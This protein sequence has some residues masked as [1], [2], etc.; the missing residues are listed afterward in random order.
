MKTE[1]ARKFTTNYTN[2]IHKTMNRI[3][4]VMP[5]SNGQ[6][7]TMNPIKALSS[8]IEQ[9]QRRGCN[10]APK[11]PVSSMQDKGTSIIAVVTSSSKDHSIFDAAN[12]HKH[13][14]LHREN[15][16]TKK[17]TMMKKMVR[18]RQYPVVTLV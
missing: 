18:M 2:S 1:E 5:R 9:Q 11:I 4:T 3:E 6:T 15:S 7:K 12:V 8:L 14:K 17:I 13:N 16:D 10:E